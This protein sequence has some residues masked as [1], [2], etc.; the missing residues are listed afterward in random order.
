[1]MYSP[2]QREGSSDVNITSFI[3]TQERVNQFHALPEGE[4]DRFIRENAG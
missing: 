1:M 3:I 2:T 4:R